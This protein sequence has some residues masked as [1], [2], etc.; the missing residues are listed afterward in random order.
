MRCKGLCVNEKR[1]KKNSRNEYC[2][3]H[4]KDTCIVCYEESELVKLRCKHIICKECSI[5]WFKKHN[6]CPYC[7]KYMFNEICIFNENLLGKLELFRSS[8]TANQLS[9]LEDLNKLY[10]LSHISDNQDIEMLNKRKTFFD[11]LNNESI[12]LFQQYSDEMK[13]TVTI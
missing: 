4:T 5:S 6:T 7:R 10:I 2:N 8:L 12:D 13:K 1:C 11:S 9:L 3:I